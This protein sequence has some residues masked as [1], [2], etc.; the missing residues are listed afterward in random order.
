MVRIGWAGAGLLAVAALDGDD[1]RARLAG[2]QR[3]GGLVDRP[4]PGVH[5]PAVG[6]D[7]DEGVAARLEG[8]RLGVLPQPGLD[9]GHRLRRQRLGPVA[10]PLAGH[11]PVDRGRGGQR[12]RLDLVAGR[13]D[14]DVLGAVAA[15]GAAV[16]PRLHRE[17]LAVAAVAPGGRARRDVRA[18]LALA[19]W[20]TT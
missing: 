5:R 9:P 15:D 4:G 10:D 2:R 19:R 18:A 6:A 17:H 16:L 14:V 13:A 7:A 1:E 12:E 3:G 11:R 8:E 20:N